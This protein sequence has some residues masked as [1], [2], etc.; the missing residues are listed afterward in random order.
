MDS[1]IPHEQ[2]MI[3]IGHDLSELEGRALIAAMNR[4]ALMRQNDINSTT[5]FCSRADFREL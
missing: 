4:I 5:T 1:D 3:E 2:L